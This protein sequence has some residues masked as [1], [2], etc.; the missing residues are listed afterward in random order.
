M[1][2]N[3]GKLSIS[4]QCELLGLARSSYYYEPAGESEENLLLMRLL[5]QQ[6]L[7]E[8]TW[9]SPK[10]TDWLRKK[11][12]RPINH[13]R[14]ERLMRKMGLYAVMPRKFKNTSKSGECI[15]P[16]L[17]KGI[18]PARANQAWCSDITYVPM[19]NGFMYL[20]AIMDWFSRFV[21]SWRLSNSL[22]T[23]FCIDALEDALI[24]GKPD[25]FNSDRG[26]QYTSELFTGRLD[27]EK[28]QISMSTKL[29]ENILIERLWRSV[30]YDELYIKE[31]TKV[32]QVWGGLE[33]Y[34]YRYNHKRPHQSLN[35]KTPAEV[36]FA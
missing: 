4:K 20:V 31:Y 8:P 36:Y 15:Y 1:E 24:F 16:Y 12:K 5:D 33:N 26:C 30:K 18:Q 34:F 28:I 2:P 6:Y 19:P 29:W 22:E 13:K 25:I 3:N 10:M 35:N 23:H 17:L 9:G 14:V 11:L 27:K 7:D 32:P 21:L